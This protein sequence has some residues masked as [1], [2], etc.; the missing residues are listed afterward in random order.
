MSEIFDGTVEVQNG[1][2]T[3]TVLLDGNA[4]LVTAGGNGQ[5]GIID[6]QSATTGGT[7]ML[8]GD[9]GSIRAGGSGVD[10]TLDVRDAADGSRVLLS[11]TSGGGS[12]VYVGDGSG[13]TE[14][15]RASGRGREGQDE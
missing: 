13:N 15:G 3:T 5:A 1:G 14:I 11:G 12:G 8:L 6:V 10:G 2:A 4:G 7:V 9:S